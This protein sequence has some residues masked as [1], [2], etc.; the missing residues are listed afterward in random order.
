MIPN[1]KDYEVQTISSAV[2]KEYIEQYHYSH[3]L[4]ACKYAFSLYDWD[5]MKIVGVLVYGRPIG[6]LSAQSISNIVDPNNV[7]ELVRLWVDDSE[8]KNTGSWFIS[9][10][11]KMLKLNDPSIEVIMSYSDPMY[12]HVGYIYQSTNW[13]YQGNGIKKGASYLYNIKG[14][15]LH[16]KT[17]HDIYGTTKKEELLKIDP[18]FK[19]VKILKKHRYIYILAGKKRRRKIINNLKHSVVDYPKDNN[20][21]EY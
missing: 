15:D 3:K 9:Q 5:E 21:V 4:S 1:N 16:E 20:N 13:L 11:F 17:C 6:R 12:D 10:T 2:A 18:E 19:R 7:L 14:K 8:G